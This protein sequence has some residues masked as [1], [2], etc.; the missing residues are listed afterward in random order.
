MLKTCTECTTRCAVDLGECPQCGGTDFATGSG[1]APL[2][3]QM[4]VVCRT[5]GCRAAGKT[6]TVRLPSVGVN[7]VQVPAISCVLCGYFVDTVESWP[8]VSWPPEARQEGDEMPKITRHG[9]P[10]NAGT[11]EGGVTHTDQPPPDGTGEPAAAALRE[12]KDEPDKD[13]TYADPAREEL[14]AP[15]DDDQPD[16]RDDDSVAGRDDDAG[17]QQDGGEQPSASSSS[18]TSS[19]TSGTS[20]QPSEP[21][22]PKR[23]RTTASRSSKARTGSSSAPSTDGGQTEP[24]SETT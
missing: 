19:P 7:L 4:K 11:P 10:S 15:R 24:T 22:P 21:A 3:P 1:R 14:A 9:G 18:E 23:A 2:L 20:T 6:Q 8:P 16:Q 12:G 17:E 13:R 5:E